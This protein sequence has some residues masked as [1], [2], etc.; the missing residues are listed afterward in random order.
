VGNEKLKKKKPL[1]WQ[2]VRLKKK[3]M[4]KAD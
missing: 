2:E 1:S 4:K 3:M